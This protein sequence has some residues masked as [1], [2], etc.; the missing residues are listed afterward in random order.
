MDAEVVRRM[1]Q[2]GLGAQQSELNAVKSEL[3]ALKGNT[4]TNL[5][6]VDS[7]LEETRAGA[8]SVHHETQALQPQVQQRS[9]QISSG[10]VREG[11]S[12]VSGT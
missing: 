4:E 10:G 6:R 2:E 8:T 1:I 5:L 12:P 3:Q 11:K 7:R 9:D